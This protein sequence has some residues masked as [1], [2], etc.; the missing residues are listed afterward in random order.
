MSPPYFTCIFSYFKAQAND[1]FPILRESKERGKS[2]VE[3]IGDNGP[4]MD[5]TNNINIFY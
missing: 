1:M 2:F 4:D 5:P 3:I